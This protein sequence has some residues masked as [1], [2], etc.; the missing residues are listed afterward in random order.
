M[1]THAFN[2][3]EHRQRQGLAGEYKVDMTRLSRAMQEEVRG[4]ETGESAVSRRPK[5]QKG[6][7]CGHFI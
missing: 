5:V 1:V 2:V 6:E 4:R 3:G 7:M